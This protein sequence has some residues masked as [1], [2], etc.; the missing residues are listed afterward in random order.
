MHPTDVTTSLCGNVYTKPN[1]Y[2]W[3]V[4]ILSREA[5]F[6]ALTNPP[7]V[8]MRQNESFDLNTTLGRLQLFHLSAI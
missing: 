7:N 6:T 3:S 5:F 4:G 2:T 1:A 8:F